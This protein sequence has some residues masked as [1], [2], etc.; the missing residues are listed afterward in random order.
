MMFVMDSLN[1][2]TVRPRISA[3][4]V[5]FK[6]IEASYQVRDGDPCAVEGSSASVTREAGKIVRDQL[7]G[8]PKG[9]PYS[10]LWQESIVRRHYD[11]A[12]GPVSTPTT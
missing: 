1:L 9:T 7:F 3:E 4:S 2:I 12:V 6:G 8:T 11:S 5:D 10:N